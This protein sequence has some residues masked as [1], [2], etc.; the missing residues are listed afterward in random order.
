[1]YIILAVLTISFND[2]QRLLVLRCTDNFSSRSYLLLVLAEKV[3]R[4]AIH[5]LYYVV[6]MVENT[7]VIN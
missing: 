3:K 1:M 5:K 2:F 6:C 7:A 4:N